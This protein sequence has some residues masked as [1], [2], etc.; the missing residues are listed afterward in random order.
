MHRVRSRAA[1]W[2]FV[3]A[4]AVFLVDRLTKIWA[5]SRLPGRPVDVIPGVLTFRFATN[6]GGAFSLGQDWPWFFVGASVIVS[7]LI[8]VTAFR[9]TS[10]LTAVALGL[11]L[12]G[13]LGNLTDRLTR[14]DGFS[15]HVVDFVDLQVWPVFNVADAAIVVGAVLL[16]LSSFV[17]DGS[18]D[19][20]DDGV[21]G[22]ADEGSTG[23]AG[24]RH[25]APTPA[26]DGR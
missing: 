4:G 14:G 26:V 20:V 22:D 1:A 23:A 11:V 6:P 13:A 2:L 15:G 16:A 3:A 25:D 8:V 12:G 19:E 18:G 7:V 5:E 24:E 10:V 9:H 21:G 17:G